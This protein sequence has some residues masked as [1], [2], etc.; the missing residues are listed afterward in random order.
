MV[1][2]DLIIAVTLC[3]TVSVSAFSV[4]PARTVAPANVASRRLTRLYAD[5]AANEASE[6]QKADEDH[7]LPS[8][9]DTDI[10]N[11]PAFLKR[12]LEVLKSD[13]AKVDN[14]LEQIKEQVA[15]GKAEWGPQLDDLQV[16]VCEF[17][18]AWGTF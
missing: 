14:D 13:V 1:R 4:G 15:A 10:L 18:F 8:E 2:N 17:G 3:L 6:P 16:E 12:K 11:S 9:S 7:V 5:E